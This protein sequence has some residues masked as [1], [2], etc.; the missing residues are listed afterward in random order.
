MRDWGSIDFFMTGR[1]ESSW[2][3]KRSV[4]IPKEKYAK[5]SVTSNEAGSECLEKF[6]FQ[7][8]IR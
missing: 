2:Y 8:A 7:S 3:E 5:Y 1:S 4:R 6:S